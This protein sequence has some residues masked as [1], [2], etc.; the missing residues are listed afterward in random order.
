MSFSANEHR[1]L[2]ADDDASIRFFLGELLKKEGFEFDFAGTGAEALERLKKNTYS[3]V[4]L[5][6]KMPNMSGIEVLRHIKSEGYPMP[7]I[8]VTAYGSKELAMRAI[9]DGA[10]DFF[11][12]PVDIGIVR[13]VIN[14]AIEK[15]E[16]QRE[17]ENL[18]TENLK[19]I[20]RD[21]IIAESEEMK[22]A[23]ELAMKVAATD[24]TALITGES[25][26]GKELIA[27]AIHKMSD[28][29][30]NPFVSVNCAAIPETLLESELFGYEKGAFTGAAKQHMGKFER[31]SKG[32]IFLDEIGDVSPGLQAKLL[33]VLQNKEIERL[34]GTRPIKVD[35]RF[36]SATNKNLDSAVRD[37]SFREDL[38]Y[39]VKVFEIKVPP[40]RERI[41]D[42]PIL[43][44]YFV[45]KYSRTMGRNVKGI[46]A[47]AINFFLR[48]NWPG[49]VREM[50]NL[51]QRAIILEDTD[52]VREETVKG[53]IFN[54]TVQAEHG[55]SGVKERVEAIKSEEE[56]KLIINALAEARWKRMEAAA[57]LGISRK[58]LFNKMK[59]YGLME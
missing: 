5:D 33:R 42:I 22:Q 16:L 37:G 53:L 47:S 31:A 1:I 9:R 19:G 41:K 56:K 10:Y 43:S 14:R 44:D 46:S 54:N 36:I 32:S 45:K 6:E 28:R 49:N 59:K 55:G 48:Y 39:R 35:M 8:M 4:L 57:R 3:L 17:I 18:K 24:V 26:S 58:S 25:G 13:T 2:I 40:L 38:L 7:V 34:G 51:I 20:L 52:T 15:Y 29:K 50:E 11:T 23:V 21:E 30:D 27:R 12:K